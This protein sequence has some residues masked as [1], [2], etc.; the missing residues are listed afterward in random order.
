ME[1]CF[2]LQ[3]NLSLC[4]TIEECWDADPEARP[5]ASCLLNRMRLR[6]SQTTTMV[7]YGVGFGCEMDPDSAISRLG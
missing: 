3:R 6:M 4:L 2:F 7:D 5:S 1:F